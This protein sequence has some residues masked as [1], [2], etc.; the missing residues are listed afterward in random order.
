MTWT[1]LFQTLVDGVTVGT[2]Y[3]LAAVGI[4]VMYR[5]SHIF[6][7]AQGNLVL[8]GA[9][10]GFVLIQSAHIPWI[11]AALLVL[12]LGGIA[13][14]LEE[15]VGIRPI[16]KRSSRATG[17]ILTTLAIT[18]IADNLIGRYVSDV[19]V[20]VGAPPGLSTQPF[21]VGGI[22]VQ[23]YEVA[24]WIGSWLLVGLIALMYRT[25][26]GRAVLAL[27][28]DSESALVR[29]VPASAIVFASWVLGG[30]F[31]MFTGLVAA[32]I[33]FASISLGATLLIKG[34][35]AAAI[36]GLGDNRGAM[37]GGI[38]VGVVESFAA[39][40][41]SPGYRNLATFAVLLAVLLLR[42]AGVFGLVTVREV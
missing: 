35:E 36:G 21:R 24:V 3:G 39:I 42:P 22:L 41:F 34:F 8:V 30:A 12:V 20:V 29:G 6:N 19:P 4:N 37:V 13:G 26:H 2:L 16:L 14:G 31:A 28:E 7:F 27:A 25:K 10:A 38:T 9:L 1:V 11:G 15:R 23:S 40:L 5:P 17:W 33:T 18:L 32:P